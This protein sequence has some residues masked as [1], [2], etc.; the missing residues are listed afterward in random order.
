MSSKLSSSHSNVLLV[1]A[2]FA[3]SVQLKIANTVN[4]KLIL[5]IRFFTKFLLL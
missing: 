2:N 1:F 5:I 4:V 3:N